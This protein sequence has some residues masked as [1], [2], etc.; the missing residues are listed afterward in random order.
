VASNSTGEDLIAVASLGDV[1]TSTN[2]GLAWTNRTAGTAASGMNWTAVAS[3]ASG[4]NL[5][6]VSTPEGVYL[7][8]GGIAETGGGIWTSTDSGAHWT[9]RTAGTSA[10]TENW[11][12]VASDSTGAHL[13]AVTE[14]D[15][16]TSTNSGAT[17][18]NETT[19]TAASGQAWSAVASDASGTHLVAVSKA[20]SG[21]GPTGVAGGDLWTSAD[22]GATWTNRTA[23]TVATGQVWTSV[24]SDATG[25]HLVGVVNGGGI[26][27][28]TN[29]GLTWTNRTA[30]TSVGGPGVGA[31]GDSLWYSVASD[32]TGTYLV[33]AEVETGDDAIWTSSNGGATWTNRTA[34]TSPSGQQ[35]SS[36]TS[37]STGAHLAASSAVG[38]WTN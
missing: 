25:V 11:Y 20:V 6:A 8:D 35:W 22:S 26:W 14:A 27:T 31:A 37:D 29:S 33:A 16:W 1:W 15:V 24:A 36:V 5:V 38:L 28:S 13:V 21:N 10:S 3:D 12:S 2:S 34:G 18:T 30:G 7:A 23:A 19:G 32:A 4:A 9:N 17:W